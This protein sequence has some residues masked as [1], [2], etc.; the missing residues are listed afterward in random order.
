MRRLCADLRFDPDRFCA[1]P[2]C[3]RVNG[4]AGVAVAETADLPLIR[5]PRDAARATALLR[6]ERASEP[7]VRGPALGDFRGRIWAGTRVR[8]SASRSCCPLKPEAPPNLIG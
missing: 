7:G 3:F 1:A 2:G 4:A 8:I 6:Q 5:Q